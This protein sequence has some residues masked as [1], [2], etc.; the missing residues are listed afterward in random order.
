MISSYMRAR[1]L[2]KLLPEEA[3]RGTNSKTTSVI[4]LDRH[5]TAL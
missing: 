2:C 4:D 1:R 5:I 3:N